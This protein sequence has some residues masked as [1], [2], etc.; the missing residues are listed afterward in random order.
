MKLNS[1]LL[2]SCAAQALAAT[3]DDRRELVSSKKIQEKI[4]TKKYEH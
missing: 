1:L 4:K 3:V 2:L